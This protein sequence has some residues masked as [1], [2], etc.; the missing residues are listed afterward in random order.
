MPDGV[1]LVE[2]NPF[3]FILEPRAHEFPFRY[4]DR[5]KSALRPYLE[6][7]ESERWKILD[8][9]RGTAGL[10]AQSRDTISFLTDLNLAIHRNIAYQRRDE[11]GT[12]S[13]NDTVGLGSG[14]CRAWPSC[15][16]H[17]ADNSVSLRG[18]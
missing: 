13:A 18:S 3:D 5:E 11:E 14:S 2:E 7:E 1:R 16:S 15:W 8:W 12:Q 9:I 4:D 6:P 17:R 10:S